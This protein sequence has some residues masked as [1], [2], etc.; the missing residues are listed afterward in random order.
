M[1]S[2]LEQLGFINN[3]F[4]HYTAE[5][6]PN[7]AEYAVRPPYLQTTRSRAVSISTFILFGDRGVGKSATRITLFDELWG[8][9]DHAQRPLVLNFIDFSNLLKSLKDGEPLERKIVDEVAFL[10]IEQVL[11]WLASLTDDERDTYTL[12]MDDSES[13]LSVALLKSF[14][15]S[16][17]EIDRQNT[18]NSALRLL[19]R[20]WKTKS[21]VWMSQRWDA[22][23]RLMGVIGEL[24]GKRLGSAGAGE[25]IELLMRS[26]ASHESSSSRLI[27]TK[28]VDFV[29]IFS[30]SGIVILIDKVDETDAT[31]S[32]SEMT[33][34]LVH[35]ILSNIQ[36]LEIDGFSWMFFLW[37]QV[38]PYFE[39]NSYPV[40]LDK[41]AHSTI[42]WEYRFFQ[43]M[44]DARIRYFS[45]SRFLFK[46][47]FLHTVDVNAALKSLVTI[48]MRSPRELVRL[49]DVIISEHDIR[50]SE[51]S[52]TVFLD[53][54]AIELGQDKYVKERIGSVYADKTLG[55]IY[56]LKDTKFI[57]KD[58]QGAFRINAQ[59]ARARIKN[60]EDAGIVKRT[61][62]RT[63]EGDLGGQPAHEFSIVDARV[64]RIITRKLIQYDDLSDDDTPSD[65]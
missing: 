59:S 65:N 9:K 39:G 31:Q 13:E 44:L 14:Y 36:L 3:P 26:F 20:A 47:L 34:R 48:S 24:I 29:K 5:T 43:E 53:E 64:E 30:F 42:E 15:L 11:G 17:P 37:A 32:S 45:N 57:N 27:L 2:L 56:R 6:E 33:S 63:P 4:E 62:T 22:L 60:W 12:A 50:N 40:R 54:E 16:K 28:L 38:K 21:S 58:V 55:Q 7:I 51:T 10:V 52:D 41:I 25:P 18:A 35:P 49:M 61:G 46:D 1:S 19:N 23:A 8:V